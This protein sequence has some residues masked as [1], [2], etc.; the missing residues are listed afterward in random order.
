MSES[1]AAVQ[2]DSL[3]EGVS[4]VGYVAVVMKQTVTTAKEYFL[5]I[6]LD[7][8]G[9]AY[10]HT[11][12]GTIRA[13][14]FAA[15]INK[16]NA[17]ARWLVQM[18]V[19]LSIDGTEATIAWIPGGGVTTLRNDEFIDFNGGDAFPVVFPFDVE[20]G[21]LKYVASNDKETTSDVN[22]SGTLKNVADADVTPAVGDVI[23]R[24]ERSSGIGNADINYTAWYYTV[25]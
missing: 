11:L 17:S 5:L 21:D 24:A 19:I 4:D 20:S 2:I 1:P 12:T 25:A 13:A 7:N 9:S 16:E 10:K 8:A 3:E 6:D 15:F 18:G 14:R 23:L 22:T